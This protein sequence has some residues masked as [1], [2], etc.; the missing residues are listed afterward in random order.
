MRRTWLLLCLTLVGGGVIAGG[1]L[2]VPR[3]ASTQTPAASSKKDLEVTIILATG[4]EVTYRKQVRRFE[5][6][7]DASGR[8][9]SLHLVLAMSGEKDTHAWY[10]FDRIAGFRH[11]YHHITGR[12]K[13]RVRR[14]Y[15]YP[16]RDGKNLQ[17]TEIEALKPDDFR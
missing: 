1:V 14:L 17:K 10:N 16:P 5:I 3:S 7:L 2:L 11:R 6:I 13:V 4:A 9:H 12:A 15:G 8:V